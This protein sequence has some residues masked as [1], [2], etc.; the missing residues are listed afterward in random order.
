MRALATGFCRFVPMSG[1]ITRRSLR[2]YAHLAIGALGKDS[3]P[4]PTKWSELEEW[5]DALDETKG[6]RVVGVGAL[7]ALVGPEESADS[8]SLSR[9][10]RAFRRRLVET[11]GVV[12]TEE[13]ALGTSLSIA[14]VRTPAPRAVVLALA[15]LR[16]DWE[17]PDGTPIADALAIWRHARELAL[18]MWYR[19]DSPA[20]KLWLEARRAWCS[21]CREVLS[22]NR[23]NLDSELQVARAVDVGH[24]PRLEEPLARWRAIKDSFVPNPVPEWLSEDVID[25]AVAIARKAPTLVWYEHRAVADALAVR[26]FD[27]YGAQGRN[28]CGRVIEDAPTDASI[29]AS[30][31]SNAEGRNLQ[32]WCRNLVI[33]PPASGSAWEQLLGRTHR[34]GQEADEVSVEVLITCDEHREA[35]EQARADARYVQDSTGQPQKLLYADVTE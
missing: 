3:A 7:E 17:L 25:A 30:I 27:V 29:A 16:A 18:G 31:A 11:P 28:G 24:Y 1:T 14:L 20:P 34:E 10:R 22:T 15:K 13:R 32:A 4:V 33:S 9:C 6:D 23:R 19:W 35:F 12:A 21:A 8:D 26:G 2:D 5:A